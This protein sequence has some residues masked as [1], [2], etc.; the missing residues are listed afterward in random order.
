MSAKA[1]LFLVAL[2]AC[3]GL[4]AWARR[5]RRGQLPRHRGR[6]L[7]LRAH[8]RL[9]PGPGHARA[10]EL[11]L[12]WG[13]LASFRESGRTRP[14]LPLWHRL[15]HP[16]AH[17]L[18][19]GT[20]HWFH[21]LRV[22]VQENGFVVGPPRFFKSALLSWLI[23]EAPG[24][25]VNTSSKPD[26]Y[27][28]TARAR[29]RRGP[30]WVFNPQQVGGIPS[31][32]QWDPLE[33]CIVPATAIRRADAFSA[34]ASVAGTEEATFWQGKAS[35]SMRSIFGAA[36]LAGADMTR[37]G[38]WAGGSVKQAVAILHDAG[39]RR[40]AEQL[41]KLDGEAQ[42]TAETIRM[43]LDRA[44]GF[45]N[46][47]EL[48]L[49]VTPAAGG[50]FDIDRFLRERGTLYM[51]AKG[52]G[53]DSTVGPLFAAL[54]DE[55]VHRA[56]QIASRMPGGRLDPPLHLNLD[57]VTSICP[58]PLPDWSADAGGQ[59]ITI[60][61]AFHG[62]AQLRRRWGEHGAQSVIDT[63][64][65]A[66]FMPGIKDHKTLE[67]ISQLCGT[68]AYGDKHEPVLTADMIRTL[69]KSFALAVRNNLSPVVFKVAAGWRHPEFRKLKR[70]PEDRALPEAIEIDVPAVDAPLVKASANGHKHVAAEDLATVLPGPWDSQ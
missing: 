52:N 27:R 58:V 61:S 62:F 4:W 32:V 34:A 31:T 53:N 26:Q 19:I 69:P 41:A 13:R 30:V 37:V 43:V 10:T 64:N 49:A 45:L 16:R 40:E 68:A 11:W 17:S 2:A 24:A 60:W 65:V 48:A 7:R 70:L 3:A 56:I 25:V 5:P 15:T 12:R 44:L 42:K 67:Q 18:L 39:R 50:G 46:D 66:V 20:A 8:L 59:G 51:I 63:T 21:R 55:I 36:S 14:S 38:D 57:E 29:G 54:A 6:H 33:G 9:H 47:P 1:V 22:S 28:L 35:D 23:L